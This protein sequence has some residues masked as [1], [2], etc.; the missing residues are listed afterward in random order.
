MKGEVTMWHNLLDSISKVQSHALFHYAMVSASGS[1]DE[2][3]IAL[4]TQQAEELAAG[5]GAILGTSA[6]LMTG[7]EILLATEADYTIPFS[8]INEEIRQKTMEEGL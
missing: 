7:E 5:I 1:T 4:A 6:T 8:T 2:E 3:A